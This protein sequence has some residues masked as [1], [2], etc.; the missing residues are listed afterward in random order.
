[1]EA[2]AE[3]E[4]DTCPM[5]ISDLI[6]QAHIDL[7]HLV[8]PQVIARDRALENIPSDPVVGGDPAGSS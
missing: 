6:E 5:E 7:A 1:M 2:T 4:P 3:Q 8:G